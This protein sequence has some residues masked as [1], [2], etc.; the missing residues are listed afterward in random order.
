MRS[1]A[2]IKYVEGPRVLDVG[3]TDHIVK[4]G[5]PEWLHGR[6]RDHFEDV[7]GI[8]ISEENLNLMKEYGIPNLYLQSA[9]D[10]HFDEPFDTI[11]A[12][13]LIEHLS[14]PGM[15]LETAMKHLKSDGHI[16]LSTPYVFSLLYFLY[17]FLKFPKTCQNCEHTGWFCIQTM[18][19]LVSRYNL[20]IVEFEMVEDYDPN[21]PSGT[22]RMFVRLIRLF[23]IVIPR[24]LRQNAMIFVLAKSN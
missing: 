2:I 5:K 16:V 21:D 19:E 8:D 3:C 6:L 20:K 11:V 14:N 10:F 13:E 17:A 1:E 4:I 22:Y 18:K 12:G 7:T 15:F 23:R 9:E 24:R